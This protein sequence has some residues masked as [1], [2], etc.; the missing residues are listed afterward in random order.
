MKKIIIP[1]PGTRIKGMQP[2]KH[3][4]CAHFGGDVVRRATEG[5]GGHSIHDALL[6][7]AEVCQLTV[8]LRIQ[9]DVVQL[10]I[11]GGGKGR[12]VGW[13]G[14]WG[15]RRAAHS[16]RHLV[17]TTLVLVEQSEFQRT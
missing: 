8:S 10:Q 14:R 16:Q 11:P 9:Q 3:S 12:G 15:G 5:G 6:A 4:G 13:W 17:S 2:R 7:H 1:I